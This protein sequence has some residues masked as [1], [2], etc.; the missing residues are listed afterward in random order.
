MTMKKTV[1]SPEFEDDY[2]ALEKKRIAQETQKAHKIHEKE[3]ESHLNSV[4]PYYEEADGEEARLLV[5]LNNLLVNRFEEVGLV[6][7][8]IFRHTPS[9]IRDYA[10]LFWDALDTASVERIIAFLEEKKHDAENMVDIW[11]DDQDIGDGFGVV[12]E[13]DEADADEEDEYLKEA[14]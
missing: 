12:G 8:N 9:E 11:F 2:Y 7:W 14:A 13:V 1:S 3:V 10:D 6:Y 4:I 5:L